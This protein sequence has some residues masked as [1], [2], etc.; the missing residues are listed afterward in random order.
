MLGVLGPIAL[1][2]DGAVGGDV[3]GML[4]GVSRSILFSGNDHLV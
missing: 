4:G 1:G 2:D 3:G